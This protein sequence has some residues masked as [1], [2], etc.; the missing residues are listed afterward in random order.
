MLRMLISSYGHTHTH[1][2]A[3]VF[4][5]NQGFPVLGHVHSGNI[6]VQDGVCRLGGC[7]NTLLGYRNR[8]YRM[9]KHHLEHMDVIMFGKVHLLR[10]SI[11]LCAPSIFLPPTTGH[12]VFEMCCGYELTTVVPTAQDYQAVRDVVG[13]EEVEEV[14]R[15]IFTDGFPHGIEHVSAFVSFDIICWLL[16]ILTTSQHLP[17]LVCPQL[18]FPFVLPGQCY[19]LHPYRSTPIPI[20]S[21]PLSL[22]LYICSC[23]RS[24]LCHYSNLG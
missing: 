1:T 5:Y 23:H 14:L 4:L 21:P 6:F 13:G 22:I 17:Y 7:E 8:F 16:F 15:C 2:Q 9:C 10:N 3:M 19:S 24:L 20:Y 18:I 11:A 12:L